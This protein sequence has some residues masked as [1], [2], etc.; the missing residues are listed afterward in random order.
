MVKQ[1][2]V[3]LPVVD[4]SKSIRFFTALG[5]ASD[6]RFTDENATCM[7]IADN[8]YA[9]LLAEPFFKSFIPEKE[10]ADTSRSTEVL[11]ALSLHQRDEVDQMMDKAIFAGGREYRE[12]MDYGW[13]Y[14]RAFQ[15]LDGHIWEVFYM[16]ES[17]MPDEMKNKGE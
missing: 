3:N 9:M 4:L 13:M 6:P 2:F 7:I 12:A 15:D 5:F 11:V 17:Q 16:D 8:M 14:G 1:I 10:I